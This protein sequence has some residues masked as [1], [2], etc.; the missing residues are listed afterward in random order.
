[1]TSHCFVLAHCSPGKESCQLIRTLMR[2]ARQAMHATEARTRTLEAFPTGIFA[3]SM[4]CTVKKEN[5]AKLETR[6]WAARFGGCVCEH[7]LKIYTSDGTSHGL[8]TR[9]PTGAWLDS[10]ILRGPIHSQANN[11]D[12]AHEAPPCN[13]MPL[14][15]DTSA[16]SVLKPYW[17]ITHPAFVPGRIK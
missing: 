8:N 3:T 15:T 17:C 10:S 13:L 11:A 4:F 2:L 1:M 16:E 7:L 9:V 14:D 6:F 5:V 12:Q